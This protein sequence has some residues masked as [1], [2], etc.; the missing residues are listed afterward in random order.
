MKGA[1]HD[2]PDRVD[3]FVNTVIM[4]SLAWTK[5]FMDYL[6]DRTLPADEVES[7]KIVRRT[8]GY[9]II[10]GQLYKR[11]TTGGFLRCVS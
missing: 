8:N 4:T 3:S 2:N 10:D 1:Y 9:V 5:P 7:Q 6:Q 11:S